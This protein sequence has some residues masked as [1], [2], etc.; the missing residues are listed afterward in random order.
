MLLYK[1]WK[2]MEGSKSPRFVF[3]LRNPPAELKFDRSNLYESLLDALID[4]QLRQGNTLT[5]IAG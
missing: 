3:D 1:A 5:E 2:K 4:D